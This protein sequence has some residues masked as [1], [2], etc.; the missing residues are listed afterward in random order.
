MFHVA[1]IGC[2]K[3]WKSEGATGF[4]M[5]HAHAE[6][7]K[8]SPDCTITALA[9]ISE[10]NAS[11]FQA[12]H[13]GE[14][15]YRDYHEMLAKEAL[16]I[17]SIST[18]PHLH[19]PMVLACAEARVKAV[20]CEK[21]MAPT[22]GEAKLMVERCAANGVQL[23]FNHQRR[24][25]LP[26]RKAKEL[27][28]TGAIGDLQKM[29]AVCDNMI[30]WGTH[31]FDMLNF[32]NNETPV[33]WVIG[34]VEQRGSKKIFGLLVEGQGVS[35]FHYANGVQGT[36]YTGYG[37]G[38]KALIRLTG[39]EGMIEVGGWPTLVRL[40]NQRSNGWQ[41]VE[42]GETQGDLQWVARGVLDLVE[43]L[44][45]GRQAQ[46]SAQRALAATEMIFATYESSRRRGR[47]DLPLTIEDSPFL[48]MAAQ[49]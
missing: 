43:A 45:V 40:L 27:L 30:D 34:Q 1:F 10:E 46:L 22:F 16:D 2:G 4:G 8:Q 35:W 47:I 11:A 41:T 32:F 38:D 36:L 6:G 33:E 15:L 37:T 20:H 48:S 39:S 13:G 18:W 49:G 28:Q 3:P 26:F 23:T 12:Q 29:E 5:A 42:H 9:D 21:P 44:K 31:W 14:R 17:V 7:Y 24:F 19:A 25:G